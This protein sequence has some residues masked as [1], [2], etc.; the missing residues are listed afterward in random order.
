LVSGKVTFT[1]GQSAEWY[2]DQTG[3]LGLAPMAPGYRP[4]QADIAEFQ[5][6]LQE[7]L[8]RMGM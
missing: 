3:R 6:Q 8:A 2:L 7:E 5:R 4:P 1:D